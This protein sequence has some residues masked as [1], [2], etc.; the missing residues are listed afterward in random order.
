MLSS[1][2]PLGE[3]ARN[4]QWGLTVGSFALAASMA[5]ALLGM[6]LGTLGAAILDAVDPSLLLL[7]TCIVAIAAAVLDLLRVR[8]PSPERQVNESWIG[9][10]RGWVYGS[11]FGAQLGLG[12]VTFVVTWGVPATL[13]AELLTASAWGG[14]LVGLVFGFG[15]SIA[16]LLAGRIDRPSRLSSFHGRMAALGPRFRSATVVTLATAG[17]LA[18]VWGLL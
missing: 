15:R 9:H 2:H 3:R 13:V 12:V 7:I 17:S 14:A 1:I 8:P 10:Y 5:G 6:G 16:L 11:A 18:A 4:N